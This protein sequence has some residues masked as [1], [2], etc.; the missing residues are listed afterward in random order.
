M[1]KIWVKTL[2]EKLFFCLLAFYAVRRLIWFNN[3]ACDPAKPLKKHKSQ[4]IK[5]SV[6]LILG[7]MFA[8]FSV[9]LMIWSIGFHDN[10]SAWSNIC[11]ADITEAGYVCTRA[12]L[13]CFGVSAFLADTARK[14]ICRAE[15][16]RIEDYF[17]NEYGFP[18]KRDS[19]R[20]E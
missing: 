8:L 1:E 13:W 12:G 7:C 16:K 14:D 18:P 2:L 19:D 11:L 5:A 6:F 4:K 10:A 17:I 3:A 20:R 15:S 9:L